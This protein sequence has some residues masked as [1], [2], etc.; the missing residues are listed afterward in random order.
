LPLLPRLY[1]SALR[2]QEL[3]NNRL[4]RHLV[5]KRPGGSSA[6]EGDGAV[7]DIVALVLGCADGAGEGWLSPREHPS[8]IGELAIRIATI[9]VCENNLCL[10]LFSNIILVKSG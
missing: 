2:D 7:G 10:D 3:A 4:S 8:N 1:S 5:G 6:A 9:S